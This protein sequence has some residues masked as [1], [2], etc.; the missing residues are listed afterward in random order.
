VLAPALDALLHASDL[1][2]LQAAYHQVAS[3]LSTDDQ[4]EVT[5]VLVRWSDVQAV[6]NLLMYPVLIPA[7]SRTDWLVR[8]LSAEQAYLRLAAA[9]GVGQLPA[10]QWTEDDVDM[11]V[12]SLLHL[13]GTDT[14]VTASRAALSLGPLVRPMDA[15]EMVALLVHR[16]RGV[17]R[18]LEAGLF[19]VVGCDGLTALLD[20]GFMDDET[21]RG[22]LEVL[23]E[24]GIDLSVP[25]EKQPRQPMLAYI[26]NYSD[27]IG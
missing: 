17:R 18:N 7:Q 10:S 22:A 6:A 20:G 25:A 23:A 14:D 9:V 27:W 1:D 3:E 15:P 11:L 5:A 4:L 19:R 16:D 8:G 13:V 2:E 26:P 24:D 21:A 12:P